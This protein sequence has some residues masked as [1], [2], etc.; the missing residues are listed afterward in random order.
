MGMLLGR[1]WVGGTTVLILFIGYSSQLFIVL[2]SFRY[3]LADPALARLLVPFNVLL[4]LLL[5]NYALTVCTDPGRVPQGWEPDWR[6]LE[7][8][9]AEVKKLTG[10]PR[11]CRSCRAY[12]PPRA[13]HCRQCKRCVL[14]M[15]HH[16]PWVNNC[17]GHH[18]YGHFVRFLFFVDV[19]CAYHLWMIS[20]RAFHS[21]A[22]SVDPS[23][24][25]IVMLVLNYTACIPVL[26]AVGVFSLYHLWSVLVNTTTIEGWEKDK[27]AS[28]KRRGKI[29]EYRYPYHLGYLANVRAILG[30]NPLLWCWPQ[31]APGDGLSYPIA[32]GTDEKD[33]LSWPPRDPLP[34]RTQRRPP[35]PTGHEFTY[36]SGLNPELIRGL[37]SARLAERAAQP[38]GEGIRA[39]RPTRVRRAPYEEE[40]EEEQEGEGTGAES[41]DGASTSASSRAHSE[42]SRSR[43]PPSP[44]ALAAVADGVAADDDDD[45]PLGALASQRFRVGL[46]SAG[47]GAS[48]EDLALDEE[49]EGEGQ[50]E[51]N[52]LDPAR[53]VRIR[54]GS[55]GFEVRPRFDTGVDMTLQPAGRSP[56]GSACGDDS[57]EHLAA[58]D[59]EGDSEWEFDDEGDRRRIGPRY[60]YYVREEDSESDTD[61][62]LSA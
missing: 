55:E 10:G 29:R 16:C 51:D 52:D 54:R 6:Q 59:G 11:Y 42:R 36:G 22:F 8:G 39:R 4:A 25:Q 12:K 53:R 15:D 38:R 26:L 17:V 7:T 60:R 61:A 19:A 46:A 30:R 58:D 44:L 18:N 37:P 32:A 45:V 1:L 40:A 57:W 47:A 14:K 35:A 43:S 27:A 34:R 13:H 41:S 62:S 20:T 31:R 49:G 50:E 33:Q 3:N 56:Q 24:F 48:A 28:L 23:T 9:E 5:V 21:L 2:P